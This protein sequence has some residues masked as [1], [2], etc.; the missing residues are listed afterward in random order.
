MRARALAA[1]GW[2]RSLAGRQSPPWAF[3]TG[4]TSTVPTPF[5]LGPEVHASVTCVGITNDP[6]SL[7]CLNERRA[8]IH[9][10]TFQPARRDRQQSRTGTAIRNFVE[11]HFNGF[12]KP[13]FRTV[14][15]TPSK[16]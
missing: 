4:Q 14:R 9:P 11:I 1:S 8:W 12:A 6:H 16:M 3:G 2:R 10:G 13:S 15:S 5:M 7:I